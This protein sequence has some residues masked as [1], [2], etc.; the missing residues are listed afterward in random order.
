MTA[1]PADVRL[2]LNEAGGSVSGGPWK[3]SGTLAKDFPHTKMSYNENPSP[4][5]KSN[6]ERRGRVTFWRGWVAIMSVPLICSFIYSTSI[7]WIHS[8]PG[9][10][11]GN[12][13]TNLNMIRLFS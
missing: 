2:G 3:G 5:Y 11:Q 13:D 7:Y 12:R 4:G 6:D 8:V 1:P 10:K 9:T